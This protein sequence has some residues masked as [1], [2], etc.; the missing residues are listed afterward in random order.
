MTTHPGA[1]AAPQT[2][3]ELL[4]ALLDIPE[5]WVTDLNLSWEICGDSLEA[6]R[7]CRRLVSAVGRTGIQERIFVRN[8]GE[9]W[10]VTRIDHPAI[11]EALSEDQ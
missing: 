3:H 7:T 10:A 11:A 5:G 1:P 6:R 4:L 8:Q 2:E 9:P